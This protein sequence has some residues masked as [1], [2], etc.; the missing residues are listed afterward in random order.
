MNLKKIMMNMVIIQIIQNILKSYSTKINDFN[1]IRHKQ[2]HNPI[3]QI[4]IK[5]LNNNFNDKE[6]Y[7]YLGGWQINDL[8]NN[9]YRL[10][11]N[12]LYYENKIYVPNNLIDI[13]IEYAHNTNAHHGAEKMIH[14]ITNNM[15]L[16]WYGYQE[17]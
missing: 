10:K 6:L 1:Y 7:H 9:K 13:V 3:C 15:N 4:I 8:R 11:D 17:I 16:Y 12:I 2:Y 5:Y 14:Y